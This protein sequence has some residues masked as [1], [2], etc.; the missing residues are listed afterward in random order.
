M[1]IYLKSILDIDLFGII[2]RMREEITDK[3]HSVEYEGNKLFIE[4]YFIL[5]SPKEITTENHLYDKV[6]D[7]LKILRNYIQQ[8]DGKVDVKIYLRGLMNEHELAILFMPCD[9]IIS[10]E[11]D[12]FIE[13]YMT[14]YIQ[15]TEDEM[16]DRQGKWT[17]KHILTKFYDECQWNENYSLKDEINNYRLNKLPNIKLIQC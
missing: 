12:E 3:Q 7:R 8:L 10:A 13:S 16:A 4:L 9:V 1:T 5:N 14:Q 2:S 17:E 11:I 15:K 6:C